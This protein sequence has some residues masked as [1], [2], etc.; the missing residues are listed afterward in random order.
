MLEPMAL[1]VTDAKSTQQAVAD[2]IDRVG[3]IDV[4]VNNAGV[5]GSGAI[6]ET[7]EAEIR[8]VFE[9]NYFGAIRLI[10]LVVPQMRE[11]QSGCIINITS[12]SG[13]MSIV[14]TFTYCASKS[15]LET[16]SEILAAEMQ[17]FNVR[18][19]L[20]EPGVVLTPIFDKASPGKAQSHYQQ[21]SDRLASY[22]KKRLE[23]PSQPEDVAETIWHAITTSQPKL[24]YLVGNDAVSLANGRAK[25]SDEEYIALSKDMP[26]A[27]YAA[28]FRKI[29]NLST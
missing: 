19:A 20:V 23:H 10:Q 12:I 1:D 9:T 25:I 4:L 14:P 24:R 2:I 16:S 11:R 18:V 27:E 29:F 28:K 26:M 17:K 13:V 6:E 22:F 3:A 5:G 15:A 8:A 7:P 21:L